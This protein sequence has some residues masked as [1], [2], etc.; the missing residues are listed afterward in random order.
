MKL[1]YVWLLNGTCTGGADVPDSPTMSIFLNSYGVFRS[2]ALKSMGGLLKGQR[3]VSG[4]I[5]IEHIVV[6]YIPIHFPCNHINCFIIYTP[7]VE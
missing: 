5:G 7:S 4:N 2:E 3:I 6:R 1:Q